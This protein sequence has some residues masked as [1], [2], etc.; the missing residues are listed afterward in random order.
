MK[1][2]KAVRQGGWAGGGPRNKVHL[3]G[4]RRM[5]EGKEGTQEGLGANRERYVSCCQSEVANQQPGPKSSPLT[6]WGL[7]QCFKPKK[8]KKC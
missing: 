1:E 7:A 5:G 6:T 8:K 2:E 3:Y 4:A